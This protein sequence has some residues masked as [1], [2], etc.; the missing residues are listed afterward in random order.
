MKDKI[1]NLLEKL[2]VKK[3]PKII[4]ID[5]ITDIS[6]EYGL[7]TYEH[8]YHVSI[9][10]SECLSL[11]EMMDIDSEA[12]SLFSMLGLENSNP[13]SFKTPNIKCFFDCGDG[14]GYVFR[15]SVWYSH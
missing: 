3:F 12:K 1:K 11:K 14:D 15:G 5:E 9:T 8:N 7:E 6:D 4:S 10:T 2:L 13:F